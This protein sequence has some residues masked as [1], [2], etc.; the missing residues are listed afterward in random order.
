MSTDCKEVQTDSSS[1][2]NS[3]EFSESKESKE[4]FI[5]ELKEEDVYYVLLQEPSIEPRVYVTSKYSEFR[6][7]VDKFL[8]KWIENGSIN[9]YYCDPA[10]A[11]C[12]S[13]KTR[14]SWEADDLLTKKPGEDFIWKTMGGYNFNFLP[15]LNE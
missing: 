10:Y 7:T 12:L 14:A 13:N 5:G 15:Y 11:Y 6:T 8:K 2:K 1:K 3:N 4:T 9:D